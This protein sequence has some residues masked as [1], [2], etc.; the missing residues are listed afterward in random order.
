MSSTIASSSTAAPNAAPPASPPS[1][2]EPLAPRRRW[3]WLA[4][5]ALVVAGLGGALW[6][7]LSHR[8]HDEA[9]LVLQGNIDVRQVNL[10]FKVEGRIETLAVDEGDTVTAGQ[11]VASL[12]K[13]YFHDELQAARARRDNAAANLARLEH[14]SRPQEIAQARAQTADREATLAR[15]KADWARAQQLIGSGGISREDY[16]LRQSALRVAEA[17]LK[18]AQESQRLIEI[19]PRQEDIDVARAQLAE[20]KA[21]VVQSERR[22]AD[23]DLIAPGPGI[24][25]TRAREK[26]AIVQAGET[27]FTLTLA[28]PVWVRTYVNERDLGR[29]GPNMAA[30]VRTDSAPD[31]VYPARVGFISPTAEFTPKTVE[32]RELRTDLVYRLRVIVDN[33]DGGLR[34]GMPVTVTL[35]LNTG[36]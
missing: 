29:V 28:S 9:S 15:A 13:R 25:L 26:G 5:A 33:P 11:V 31:K 1:A 22:L 10:A 8:P 19:G 24:I 27:V 21:L 4:A 34:Q 6:F 18:S 35:N 30:L 16:D 14:G 23:S 3:P 32:T 20:Q 36:N 7:Y 12:D 17:Q 2:A